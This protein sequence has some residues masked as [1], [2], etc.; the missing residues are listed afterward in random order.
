M[1]FKL[2]ETYK[3]LGLK[4]QCEDLDERSV[5]AV[6]REKKREKYR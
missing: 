2:V 6:K 5:K 3:K 1:Y 4:S